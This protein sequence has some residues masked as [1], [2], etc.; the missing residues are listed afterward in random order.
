MIFKRKISSDTVRKIGFKVPRKPSKK[1]LRRLLSLCLAL[2]LV[3]HIYAVALKFTPVPGTILML[4]RAN[5]GETIKKDWVDLEDISP[6]LVYAVIGAE[7]SRFCD[8][9]GVDWDAV[10][11]VLD[12]REKGERQRG[13]STITQQTAKN[14]FLW[15]GGG[16]VRKLPETWAALFIDQV[17]GKRRVM[18]VYLNVAEWGDGIFG[19]EAAAQV[20]FGKSAKN[21]TGYEAALLASVLPSPNKWRLDP[22]GPYVQR[23]T[24]SL[25]KRAE[26][27]RQSGYASCVFKSDKN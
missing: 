6:N 21:L 10:Q 17:W 25:V 3:P 13:G 15:N 14:V 7:D 1:G 23:R 20:R 24:G 4:Q 11:T 26:V 5:A 22:P 9:N 8:H 18:E 2:G 27:V 16:W 19:V 12:E